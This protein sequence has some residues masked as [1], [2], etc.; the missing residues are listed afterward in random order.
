MLLPLIGLQA[1][2]IKALP[3]FFFFLKRFRTL[4]CI[5]KEADRRGGHH[6]AETVGD[7]E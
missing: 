5:H 3:H 1:F 7:I 6:L 4:I 2:K